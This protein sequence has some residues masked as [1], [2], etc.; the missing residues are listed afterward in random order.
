MHYPQSMESELKYTNAHNIP[1][2][3]IRAVQNDS[4]TKGSAVKSVTGLL[5]PPQ[6]SILS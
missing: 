4:Y 1:P 5:Q 3:I 2:E 6:I